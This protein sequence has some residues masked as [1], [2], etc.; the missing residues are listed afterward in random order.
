[1]KEDIPSG[2]LAHIIRSVIVLDPICDLHVVLEIIETVV[3]KRFGE[4]LLL[5][6]EV[7]PNSDKYTFDL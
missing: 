2:I 7:V 3:L 6:E 4:K 1:L 5:P